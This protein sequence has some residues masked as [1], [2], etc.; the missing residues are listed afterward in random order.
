MAVV[1]GVAFNKGGWFYIHAIW[2]ILMINYCES[3]MLNS[4]IQVNGGHETPNKL[5][6]EIFKQIRVTE[7]QHSEISAGEFPLA[8]R[9]T[10]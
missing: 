7:S 10:G 2:P 8:A 1:Y 4:T 3:F 5:F 6:L 9:D